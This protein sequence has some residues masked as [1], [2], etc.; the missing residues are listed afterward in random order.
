MSYLHRQMRPRESELALGARATCIIYYM[1]YDPAISSEAWNAVIYTAIINW[2]QGL[3]AANA[4]MCECHT[5]H[6]KIRW[7]AW[8]RREVL[9]R[10]YLLAG[11]ASPADPATA[12]L[13]DDPYNLT[14][15]H[16]RPLNSCSLHLNV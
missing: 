4:M 13:L 9:N 7:G 10:R 12:H 14:S 3:Q 15:H 5:P 11:E 16:R 8:N 6:G 2:L 1:Y